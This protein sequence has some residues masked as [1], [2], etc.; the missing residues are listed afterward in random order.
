MISF[1]VDDMTCGHCV[2]SITKALRVVD[3]TAQAQF[4]LAAHRVDIEPGEADAA[5]LR[6]A[7]EE[8]GYTPVPTGSPAAGTALGLAPTRKGCCCG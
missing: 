7:I 6:A 5:R 3:A 2:S 1:Q 8:A 4:D